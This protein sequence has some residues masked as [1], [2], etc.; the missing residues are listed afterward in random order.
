MT[1]ERL[2]DS[3]DFSDALIALLQADGWT[4]DS[5]VSFAGDEG[6]CIVGSKGALGFRVWGESR[7]AA[8]IA[9]LEAA[10]PEAA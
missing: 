4:V 8:A 3:T 2:G 6:I 1:I 7:G 10:T 9:A 5:Y